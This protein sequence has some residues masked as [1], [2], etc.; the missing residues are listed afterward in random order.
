MTDIR[1]ELFYQALDL[2][3]GLIAI[4]RK[5]REENKAADLFE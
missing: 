4:P 3:K 2:L 1:D 5:S